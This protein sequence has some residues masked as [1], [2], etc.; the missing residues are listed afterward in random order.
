MSLELII[1]CMYSGKSS[2]LVK[3]VNRLQI[4]QQ[5]YVIYNSVID[6]RY[7]TSGIYT[8]NQY[9]IPCLITDSL[10]SQVTTEAFITSNTI[11]IDEAQFFS[12]LYDFVK[13]SVEI[14]HKDVV[15]IGL[16]GDSDRQNFGQIHTLI[17]LADD[18]TKLKAVCCTCKDGTPGI[19]SKKIINSSEQVDIGSTDKYSA[20]CRECYLK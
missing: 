9:H 17:P 14:Y 19:F 13:V 2:E 8:H 18:I 1:G 4:I 11:F 7:G 3:R 5:S 20:V 6:T 16:D 15:V 10:L 12:D